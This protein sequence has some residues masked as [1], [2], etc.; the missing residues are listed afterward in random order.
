MDAQTKQ[1]RVPIFEVT[2]LCT[3]MLKDKIHVHVRIFGPAHEIW[4][5]IDICTNAS[6]HAHAYVSSGT[7]NRP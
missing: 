6:L 1:F 5:L 2:Y 4:L 7:R 3:G